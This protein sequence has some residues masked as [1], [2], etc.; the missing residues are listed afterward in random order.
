MLEILHKCFCRGKC[1][2]NKICM[3]AVKKYHTKL[4]GFNDNIIV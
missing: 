2:R 4:I 1:A 3:I